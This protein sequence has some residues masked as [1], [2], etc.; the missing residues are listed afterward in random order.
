M[1]VP[2]FPRRPRRVLR[3]PSERAPRRQL[4]L[5]LSS[6]SSERRREENVDQLLPC[7]PSGSTGLTTALRAAGSEAEVSFESLAPDVSS[8]VSWMRQRASRRE[9]RSVEH[10]LEVLSRFDGLRTSTQSSLTARTAGGRLRVA[11]VSY[12]PDLERE[13]GREDAQR[14]ACDHRR[15]STGFPVRTWESSGRLAM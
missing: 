5:E 1:L 4:R 15:V 7:R 8:G 2:R 12:P 10:A 6:F 14:E 13:P 11:V 9:A 3:G